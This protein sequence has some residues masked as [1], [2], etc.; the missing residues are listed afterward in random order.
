MTTVAVVGAASPVGQALLERLDADPA[1][2]AIIGIDAVEPQMPVAKLTY[3]PTDV[4]DQLLALA[5][6]GA[7]VVVHAAFTPSPARAEDAMFA[8][9]VFGTRNLLAA[10][11]RVGVRGLVLVSSAAAYGAHPDNDVPLTEDAPLRA[12]PDFSY[13]HQRRLVEEDVAAWAEANPT[14]AVTVL[15]AAIVLGPG[16]DHFVCRQ[17]EAPRIL[18]VKGCEPPL[19]FAH[20]DDVA[21]AAH[22]AVSAG[23]RGAFNVAAEGWLPLEEACHLLGRKP[24]AVPEAVA[25]ETTALLWRRGVGPAPP[26]VLAYLMHPWMVTCERLR[27]EGWAPEHSNREILREFATTHAGWLSFGTAR[28]RRRDLYL[29]GF[30]VVGLLLGLMVGGWRNRRP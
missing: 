18:T 16:V 8:Q 14:V 22:L 19:Q 11:K 15:R 28:V 21:A 9:N 12:N 13:G 25:Y 23:L 20:T 7:D 27:A 5:L 29:T 17:L 6:A 3:R 1:V 24:L 4:R 10:A 2:S 30:G 26:G